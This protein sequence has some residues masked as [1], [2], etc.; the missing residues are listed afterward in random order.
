[1]R[2]VRNCTESICDPTLFSTLLTPKND[3]QRRPRTHP[4]PLAI[5]AYPCYNVW[6]DRGIDRAAAD[7]QNANQSQV[8]L[9]R[10]HD[11]VAGASHSQSR[12]SRR[13]YTIVVS[14]YLHSY[15]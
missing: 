1:M 4:Y 10:N 11:T 3:S 8:L 13:C 2:K 5:H 9:T 15:S 7:G 14:I 6:I 12:Y